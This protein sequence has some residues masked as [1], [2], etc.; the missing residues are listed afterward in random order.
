MTELLCNVATNYVISPQK[1]NI[2]KQPILRA[3][4]IFLIIFLIDPYFL[5]GQTVTPKFGLKLSPNVGWVKPD[6][7]SYQNDGAAFAMSWGFIA[8]FPMAENY[9]ASTGFNISSYR[10]KIQYPH[11]IGNQP[12]MFNRK[13]N[14][15]YL[16]IPLTARLRV[17]D[18]GG[19]VFFGNIGL[20]S[21][22]LLDA[23][24]EDSFKSGGTE[25]S[26]EMDKISGEIK[27]FRL[28][29]LVGAGIEYPVGP[30]S[31]LL[32]GLQ[33][34]NGFTNFLRGKNS[35]DPKISH[36]AFSNMVELNLGFLF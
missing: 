31:K 3:I 28:S 34:N 5:S 22:I 33:F 4:A 21:G 17:A 27:L 19:P 8:E 15:K 11:M 1:Q 35:S 36:R 16:E 6:T 29:L 2:M 32:A 9:Y 12:G 24:A 30:S 23:R 10:S 26:T 14:L 18:R 13:Y 20:G 7:R 25:I